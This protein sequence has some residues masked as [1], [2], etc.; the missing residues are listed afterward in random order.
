MTAAFK[1]ISLAEGSVAEPVVVETCPC[2]YDDE[3]G[4]NLLNL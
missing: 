4:V 2:L 3:M 1:A